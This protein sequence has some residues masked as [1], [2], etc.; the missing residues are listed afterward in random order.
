MSTPLVSSMKISREMA[1]NLDREI[2]LLELDNAVNETKVRT[3]AGP[4]GINNSFIKNYANNC[5]KN[6]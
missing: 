6:F 3:A 5:F 4:D 2:S 1:V